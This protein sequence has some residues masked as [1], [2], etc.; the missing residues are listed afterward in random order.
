MENDFPHVSNILFCKADGSYSDIFLKNGKKLKISKNL[1]KI[2]E[3]L[4]D[5]VFFRCHHSFIINISEITGFDILSR[6][7]FIGGKFTIP[8]S[9]NIFKAIDCKICN[10]NK[11][12]IIN[13]L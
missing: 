6:K 5:Q 9:K 10:F 11:C 2:S 12:K 1:K 7:L 4:P 8:V 3:F 13:R